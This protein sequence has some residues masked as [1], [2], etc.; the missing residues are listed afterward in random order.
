MSADELSQQDYS[1]R[2]VER[3]CAI[4][5]LVQRKPAGLTIGEVADAADLPKSSAFRYLATLAAQGYLDRDEATGVYRIGPAFLPARPHRLELLAARA[6]PIMDEL[7]K[8]Y[9][10]TINLAVLDGTRVAYLEI[11]ESPRTMRL[12]ARSGDR[13]PL[14][15]TAVGKAIAVLLDE[16]DISAILRTEGMPARTDRTITDLQAFLYEVSATRRRGYAL[17]DRENEADGRCVAVPLAGAGVAAAL[18]LSAPS[19]RFPMA[20]VADVAAALSEAATEMVP[21][22]GDSS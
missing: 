1:I 9:E 8:R 13:D 4:L 12:A 14:H 17:D 16:D 15:C 7:C 19:A 20:E 18:S 22:G 11:V 2:A 5:D 6:R 3:V 21:E 10:E